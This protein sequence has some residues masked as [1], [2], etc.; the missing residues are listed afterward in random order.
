MAFI[1][2][3]QARDAM[4]GDPFRFRIPKKLRKLKVGKALG[5]VARVASGFIPGLGGIAAQMLAPEQAAAVAEAAQIPAPDA[6]DAQSALLDQYRAFARSYGYDFGGDP[7]RGKT[8]KRKAASAGPK[9]KAAAKADKRAAKA[10]GA[11][12]KAHGSSAR[13]PKE[14]GLAHAAKGVGSVVL[15]GLKDVPF[16][17]GAIGGAQGFNWKQAGGGGGRRSMNPANVHALRR[18]L[19]RV[20]GFEKLVKR[21]EKQYP[22][23]KRATHPASRAHGKGCRCASCK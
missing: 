7:G 15:G 19:R 9:V 5:K 11:A 17:G 2:Q 10:S 23:L 6:E 8:T 16:L 20:E 18:S 4:A 12:P 3:Y 13:G 21:I 22:R 14:S 1:R